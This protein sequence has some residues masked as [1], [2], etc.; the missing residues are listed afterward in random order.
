M[1]MDV[2]YSHSKNI[3]ESIGEFC[4]VPI[5][6]YNNFDL[7]LDVALDVQRTRAK[8]MPWDAV[9]LQTRLRFCRGKYYALTT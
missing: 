2:N 3:G 1:K 4:G 6:T 9:T 8:T 7:E 5:R